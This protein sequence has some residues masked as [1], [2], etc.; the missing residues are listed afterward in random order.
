MHGLD[1]DPVTAPHVRWM[2]A[3]RLA[4]RSMA[5]IARELNERGVP[6]PSGADPGRNRHRGEASC[7]RSMADY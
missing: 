4:G 3:Q 2:F 1:P 6:Y 7:R 5:G